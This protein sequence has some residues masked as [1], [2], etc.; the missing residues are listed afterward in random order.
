[1]GLDILI[2]KCFTYYSIKTGIFGPPDP[3]VHIGQAWRIKFSYINIYEY[4]YTEN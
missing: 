4:F 2:F 1:M 3:K